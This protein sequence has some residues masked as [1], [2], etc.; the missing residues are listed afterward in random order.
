MRI[1]FLTRSFNGLA[2]R[3]YLELTARGHEV[4]VEFD[5]SDAVTGEAVALF[6]PALIVA[7]FLKRAIPE[8]VWR[9]TPCLV[10]HPGIVGDRG[11]S[12]L[13]WAIMDGERE[14]GVTVL[15]AEAALDAGPVWASETFVMRDAPKSSLY[16]HEVTTAAARAVLT[17]VQRFATSA[18]P[19]PAT[20]AP[21]NG[22]WRPWMQQAARRID[23]QREDTTTVL[24]KIR[25][26]DGTPGVLDTMFG[27]P[28]HL[29]DAHGE[30]RVHDA[31]PG[32]LIARRHDAVLR[33]TPDGAVWIGQVRRADR[34]DSFK[35]PTALAFPAQVATLCEFPIAIDAP[36]ASGWREIRY[37]S[38]GDV[39]YL[40]FDFY[41]GAM[42]T[43]Q[44]QRLTAALRWALA[45]PPRVLVL[46]GGAD[47]W[48]NG[49]H[50]NV[51]EA[52]DSPAD[53]SW[54]NIQAIDDLTQT[55]I[56]ATDHVVVAAM[57]GNAGA[58]GVFMALAADQ[59][60]AH[61]GVVLNPHYK[62]MGNLY[63]SEY[64]TYLLPRRVKTGLPS[65]VMKQRLPVSAQQAEHLGLV[66][67]AF[68]DDASDFV[69]QVQSR[70]AAL[71]ASPRVSDLL[72]AKQRRRLY[73][74]ADKPLAVYRD[75]ELAH[76]RRNFYGFD[77]SYH[78]ARSNFV[79]HVPP[80]WTPRHLCLHR[81]LDARQPRPDALARESGHGRGGLVSE[82]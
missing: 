36:G 2:Q 35:L 42:S 61:R 60:W 29:F 15:Q 77:P 32:D 80:S 54:R 20:E 76:M 27:V 71:A 68:G 9:Q 50:L 4:S 78:V 11:P 47:F 62:N 21:G 19:L 18:Q 16:R 22:R 37:E 74:E 1:L 41:N 25:A 30:M 24:R 13:D 65:D 56:E 34:G 63:G 43:A 51:I 44:C 6:R 7:P 31:S 10:V 48:C 75:E 81:R 46:L 53:E 28:C 55:L 14:W 79:H 12:A 40:H 64:W 52:A 66:D 8:S 49:I 59:V 33:A 38:R 5:I 3:L 26:A 39:G 67:A 17:A 45:Q 58:G 69:R 73:D 72:R 57:Q 82:A 23:W 70:A